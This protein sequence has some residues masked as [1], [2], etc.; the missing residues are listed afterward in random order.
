MIVRICVLVLVFFVCR[1]PALLL[2]SNIG[3]ICSAE[4]M[5]NTE[6][7]F[8]GKMILDEVMELFATVLPPAETKDTMKGFIS[9]SKDLLQIEG[10]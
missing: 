6:V 5:D 3:A 8:I 9:S 2:G 1:C 10:I 7:D 4:V